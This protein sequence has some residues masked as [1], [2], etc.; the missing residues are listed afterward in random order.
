MSV[1]SVNFDKI[2]NTVTIELN[3]NFYDIES[4]RKCARE[5]SKFCSASINDKDDLE[6][7]L[8]GKGVTD[9]NTLGY[10]FCNH[11]LGKMKNENVV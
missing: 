7:V 6:I 11:V 3:R 2:T 9:M 4:V 5:F 1:K 10:E 8:K